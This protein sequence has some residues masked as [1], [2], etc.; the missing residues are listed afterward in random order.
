MHNE[1]RENKYQVIIIEKTTAP[2]GMPGDNWFRYVIQKGNLANSIIECKKTGSLKTVTEHA[3][4][5]AEIIN[6]RN[7][8]GG[9]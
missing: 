1:S 2:E 4:G 9:R 7:G 8:K 6:S 3:N 5:Q